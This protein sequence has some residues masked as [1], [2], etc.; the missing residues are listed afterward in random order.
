MSKPKEQE[1]ITIWTHS[2]DCAGIQGRSNIDESSFWDRW[3]PLVLDGKAV[4]EIK[5]DYG[6]GWEFS[7]RALPGGMMDIVDDPSFIDP[8]DT[9]DDGPWW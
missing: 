8:N 3:W 1:P 6:G 9:D 2:D 4:G 7:I 5:V